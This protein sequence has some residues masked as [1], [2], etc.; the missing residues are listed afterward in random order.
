MV[1]SGVLPALKSLCSH[2]MPRIHLCCHCLS[3]AIFAETPSLP[4]GFPLRIHAALCSAIPVMPHRC[5]YRLALRQKGA[6]PSPAKSFVSLST[7]GSWKPRCCSCAVCLAHQA[8]RCFMSPP[9]GSWGIPGVLP[10]NSSQDILVIEGEAV[11][12]PTCSRT[13]KT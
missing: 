11:T 1:S 2:T 8:H 10:F 13:S 4:C 6:T 12:S 3:F 5:L 9:Y 7:Q